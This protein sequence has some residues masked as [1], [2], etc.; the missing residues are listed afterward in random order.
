MVW[1][2]WSL[3]W[4][5]LWRCSS[6]RGRKDSVG[7]DRTTRIVRGAGQGMCP[8]HVL[9]AWCFKVKMEGESDG[10]VFCSGHCTELMLPLFNP[11]RH[12]LAFSL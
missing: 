6:E 8:H 3:P 9:G 1:G 2:L 4:P 11:F 5:S 7:L 12:S 10:V